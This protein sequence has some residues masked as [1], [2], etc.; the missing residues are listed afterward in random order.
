MLV[1]IKTCSQN[2]R[3]PPITYQYI[4]EDM[5]THSHML[6]S[7]P[8]VADNKPIVQHCLKLA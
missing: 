4:H 1:C 6:T 2:I 3:S 5:I 7:C 8:V